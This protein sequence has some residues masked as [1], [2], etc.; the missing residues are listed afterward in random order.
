MWT[1]W[2]R[3]FEFTATRPLPGTEAPELPADQWAA[4]SRSLAIFQ[5]GEGGE[6]RI[7]KDIDTFEQPWID[8]DYRAALKLFVR[9]EGRHA[10]IL[11][12]ALGE[13]GGKTLNENWTERLFLY[14]RR[15]MGIELKL[16]V[17]TAA[18]VVGITFYGE[19]MKALPECGLKSALGQLCEDETEHLAFHTAYFRAATQT[20][21][22][23]RAFSVAWRTI[24]SAAL[25]VVLLDH[26]ATLRAFRIP[27]DA[28]AARSWAL[29]REVERNV[30]Y[31]SSSPSAAEPR[32]KP[33]RFRSALAA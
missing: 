18:E 28:V 26:L 20:Q 19:L 30:L 11:T 21:L 17:L 29:I 7:A 4:L 32:A 25:S 22:R 14:G 3:H 12:N 9:E 24:A 10:R 2:R 16:T 13:L 33:N 31:P 6:G 23:K 27:P 1:E 15:A 8:E 5:A